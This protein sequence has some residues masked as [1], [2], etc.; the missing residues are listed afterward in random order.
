MASKNVFQACIS[1]TYFRF[2]DF[3]AQ[4]HET[5][6]DDVEVKYGVSQKVLEGKP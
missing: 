4:I 6:V 5:N 3:I 2:L 1:L